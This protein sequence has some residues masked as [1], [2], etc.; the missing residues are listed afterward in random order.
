LLAVYDEVF[1]VIAGAAGSGGVRAAL[2]CE[3]LVPLFKVR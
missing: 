3:P 1:G 2:R